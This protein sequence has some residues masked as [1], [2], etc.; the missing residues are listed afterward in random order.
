LNEKEKIVE[1]NET[2]KQERTE[3]TK[4]LS[5]SIKIVDSLFDILTSLQGRIKW[6]RVEDSLKRSEEDFRNFASLTTDILSMELAKLSLAVKE[7]LQAEISKETY[8]VL[9]S[10]YKYFNGL[11]LKHESSEQTHP[12][13]QDA[14]NIILAYYTLNDYMLGMMVGDKETEKEG[15]VLVS[16]LEDLSKVT[17]MKINVDAVQGIINKSD[18]DE[19]RKSVIEENRAV[20][21]EQVKEL[22]N[23]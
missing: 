14:K 21:R 10:L 19:E 15:K 9:R 13:Y 3:L 20:F 1:N 16:M 8:S 12:N 2:V 18:M 5:F 4:M 23:A 22:I 17:N 7:H 6:N 11:T